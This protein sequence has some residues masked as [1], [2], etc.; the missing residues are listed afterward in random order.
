MYARRRTLNALRFTP[1]AQ[2]AYLS[3]RGVPFSYYS[4]H[5]K[6]DDEATSLYAV[7]ATLNATRT[8]PHI[9]VHHCNLGF[10]LCNR[11][12]KRT[13][14]RTPAPD[15]NLLTW[16]HGDLQTKRHDTQY[17]QHLLFEWSRE[18]AYFCLGKK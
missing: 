8:T 11:F 5:M 1:Y 15:L 18:V 10:H 13:N 7:R 17:A 2:T 14:K 16:R 12:A 9:A 3:L 4:V 6:R